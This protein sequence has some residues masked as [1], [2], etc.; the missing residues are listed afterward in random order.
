MLL[1]HKREFDSWTEKSAVGADLR[2]QRLAVGQAQIDEAAKIGA[3]EASSYWD[4]IKSRE[5]GG[6][7][8]RHGSVAKI[9]CIGPLNYKY[10]FWSYWMD[11]NCYMGIANRMRAAAADANI[12]RIVLY[13]DSPGGT[14][15]GLEETA[16]AIYEASQAKDVV[17]VV[18]P[19]AASAGYWLA[20]QASRIV[21]LKSGWVGSVGAQWE[22]VSISEALKQAG[23]NVEVLRSAVSPH[24]NSAHPYEPIK[25]EAKKE[26]Q[27]HVDTAGQL[28]VDMVARGR[29]KSVD[30]VREKF[31]GGHMLMGPAALSVGMVDGFGTLQGELAVEQPSSASAR[32]TATA[33][34]SSTAIAS[35]DYRNESFL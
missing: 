33:E 18:D 25:E 10:D 35:R 1:V 28:F 3:V 9:D 8:E 6:E 16:E 34:E 27:A 24:K 21:M 14:T 22:Y 11:A 7:F 4:S 12:Q 20:S 5:E 30:H 26:W 15:H 29:K 23:W 32:S 2:L 13:V 17:A 19:T 31:G